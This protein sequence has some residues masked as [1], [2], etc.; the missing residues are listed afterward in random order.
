MDFIKEKVQKHYKSAVTATFRSGDTVQV[1]VKI[2]EGEKARVQIFEGTVI[3]MSKGGLNS[4]FTV[5]KSSGGVGVERTFPYYSP[6]IDKVE[7]SARGTSRRAKLYYLRG[8]EGKA[9]RIVSELQIL[10][11]PA[12]AASAAA[13]KAAAAAKA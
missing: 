7:V 6:A 3:R 5:R 2:L 9:A 11:T 13:K 1:H 12:Q 10:E 8:L 4:S